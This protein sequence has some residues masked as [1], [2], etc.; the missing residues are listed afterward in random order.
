MKTK[1]TATIL[2]GILVLGAT[3]GWAADKL[4]TRT[5][6]QTPTSTCTPGTGSMVRSGGK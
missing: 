1:V 3:A 5:H 2:A 4:K 6:I